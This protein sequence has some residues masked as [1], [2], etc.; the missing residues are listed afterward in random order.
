MEIV[1][2]KNFK[3]LSR[4]GVKPEIVKFKNFK[5]LS[6]IGVKPM[7]I[8]LAIEALTIKPFVFLA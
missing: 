3:F 2:F 8:W 1:K 5:I 6:R 4:M 7:T